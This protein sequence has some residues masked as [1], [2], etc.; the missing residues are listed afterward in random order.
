MPPVGERLLR[1]PGPRQP[2]ASSLAAFGDRGSG[3]QSK[4][5]PGDRPQQCFNETAQIGSAIPPPVSPAPKQSHESGGGKSL[6]E[7]ALQ[8][9]ARLLVR[10]A[11]RGMMEAMATP[12]SIKERLAE[13]E[14]LIRSEVAQGSFALATAS[15]A[16]VRETQP[17][18][19]LSV[20]QPSASA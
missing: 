10:Y 1:A 3:L 14:Y 4:A 6:A 17:F 19:G 13:Y 5:R 8:Q 2:L 18:L 12:V 11:N 9:L 16:R 20:S 7:L 15:P